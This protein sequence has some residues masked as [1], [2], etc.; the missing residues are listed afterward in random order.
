[1]YFW[2]AIRTLFCRIKF[3]TFW[4]SIF[5][6]FKKSF[7]KKYF[8]PKKLYL[9]PELIIN[10]NN[11]SKMK[12]VVLSLAAVALLTVVSCKDA[13]KEAV[14]E[15]AEETIEA[16]EAQAQETVEAVEEAT[17]EAAESVEEAV[18]EAEEAIEEA[19]K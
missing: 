6:P 12:K 18:E 4:I 5:K 11:L 2:H 17:E 13:N 1:K 7:P 14:E 16:V 3:L 9:C 19:A 8:E 10:L 15:Q